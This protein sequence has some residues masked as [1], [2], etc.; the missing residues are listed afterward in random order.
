MNILDTQRR[1]MMFEE[2]YA[3]RSGPG[4]WNGVPCPDRS[5]ALEYLTAVQF[6]VQKFGAEQLCH[7]I[8]FHCRKT[9]VLC[10]ITIS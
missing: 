6:W 7:R 4:I 1:Y 3:P 10:I 8:Y 2:I 5:T 9:F